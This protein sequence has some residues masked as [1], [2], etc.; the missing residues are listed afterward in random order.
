M[1]TEEDEAFDDLARKQGMW[2]GGFKAKQAMAADKLQEHWRDYFVNCKHCGK[3]KLIQ[4]G[5]HHPWCACGSDEFDWGNQRLAQPA[6]EPWNEDEWRRNNWRCHHGWLR[7]EQCE[8]CN[9]AQEPVCP[10]CKAEVLYECVACSS[11]N[12]PP[13]PV[14][15]PQYE[16]LIDDLADWK[17][18]VEADNAPYGLREH[19]TKVLLAHGIKEKNK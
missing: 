4:R 9:A 3:E 19:V 1:R 6:Q 13:L 18:Y 5:N 7:G 2:G 8:I 11:N 15:E 10:A 17:Q 16:F 14:Q 12:Y